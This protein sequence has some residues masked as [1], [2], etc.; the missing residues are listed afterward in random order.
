MDRD[1]R[2]KLS[3]IIFYILVFGILLSTPEGC[4]L[5]FHPVD[6]QTRTIIIALSGF[7]AVYI[8]SEGFGYIFNSF[9]FALWSRTRPRYYQKSDERGYSAEQEKHFNSTHM[10]KRVVD[11]GLNNNREVQPEIAQY[12]LETYYWYFFQNFASKNLNA[13]IERRWTHFAAGMTEIVA[14]F[15]AWI[16]TIIVMYCQKWNWSHYT[17]IILLF[18]IMFGVICFYNA[19][20]S[21]NDALKMMD[22]WIYAN[23]DENGRKNFQ[24]FENLFK[25]KLTID[26]EN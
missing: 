10:R 22:L 7:L 3:G 1:Y 15:F 11:F 9:F 8:S 12:S 13:W 25:E 20:L 21:R 6:D 2:F 23:C 17:S 26:S 4:S 24:H 19:I 18:S 5:I 16:L 14:I